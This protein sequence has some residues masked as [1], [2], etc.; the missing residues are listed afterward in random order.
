MPGD[1]FQTAL[2]DVVRRFRD[3]AGRR[4]KASMGLVAETLGPTD[5]VHG[6]G[7]DAAVVSAGSDGST[8]A[9]GEAIWPPFVEAD[10][11]GAGTAA[12]VA[13]VNDIA[14]MGGRSL[15]LVD[16]IVGPEPTA[17]RILEGI[18]RA[19]LL[20]RVP[21]VG[22][23]LAIRDGPPSVSAFVVGRAERVLASANAVPG[24]VL[25]VAAATRGR[26]HPG[27]P[28]FSSL[29]E[30]EHSLAGDVDVLPTIAERGWCRAA[31]DI[32]MAGTL[33]SLAMLLEPTRCGVVVDL[34]SIPRPSDVPIE[35]WLD[36]FPS[37]GF[38]LCVPDDRVEDCRSV[39][40]E[41]GLACES[42]GVLDESGRLRVR[43]GAEEAV[44]LDLTQE[45][46]TGL[47]GA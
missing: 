14:A 8:L 40:A 30:R 47:R 16:T 45:R 25:L 10:P 23:H 46:V 26:M 27:F 5:W 35:R 22:G 6:P 17:R 19:A 43:S 39:F 3:H 24:L 11:Y 15:G 2:A 33:G 29:R 36:V 4:A 1:E 18:A 44:L 41:R 7:D 42:V 20:Y 28:F 38:L 12:V 34:D 21:V 37:F 13:N 32:S 31:K 9:A